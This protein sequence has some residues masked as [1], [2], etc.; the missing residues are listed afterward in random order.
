MSSA[1]CPSFEI[2]DVNLTRAVI[3]SVENAMSMCSIE[4]R[5]V[6]LSSIP[7]REAGIV[8]S[9]IGVHGKVSGFVTVNLAERV[10]LKAVG[11]LLG[12]S[13]SQLS[14]QVVDGAG[15]ITN[16][17]TGGIKSLLV[18]SPWS[19]SHITVP[20]VILGQGYQIAYGKGLEFFNATF[21]I[22]DENALM[23]SDRLMNVSISLLRL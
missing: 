16:I 3:S 22:S 21:E 5:C 20:T 15:E 4:S 1:V 10:A 6:G 9:M 12:E 8:T 19:F 13:F 2:T 11:G 23:L 14:P 18:G 17:I 7:A